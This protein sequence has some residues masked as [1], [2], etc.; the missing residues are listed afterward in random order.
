MYW[1]EFV[2]NIDTVKMARKKKDLYYI[3]PGSKQG[4]RQQRIRNW[5]LTLLIGSAVALTV[6]SILFFLGRF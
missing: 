2:P 1:T 3:M 5:T 6:G 4:V